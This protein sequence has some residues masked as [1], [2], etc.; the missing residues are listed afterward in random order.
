[1]RRITALLAIIAC[2]SIGGVAM[3]QD[4]PAISPSEVESL[5]QNSKGKVLVLDF[6]ATW[7]PPCRQEIPGFVALQN[8]YAGK[9]VSIVGVSVDEGPV[10]VVESFAKELGI[11]YTLYHGGG[12]VA[13]K[14]RIR[15]I[16]T[17]YIYDTEGKKVKTHIGF[18]SQED[19]DAQIASL[20]K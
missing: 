15:A 8:K 17:T 4:V 10:G 9:N 20:L 12:D 14:Y 7:C 2:V 19:F 18:V 13:R 1:M 3:A 16:P 6:F 5:I 11:N